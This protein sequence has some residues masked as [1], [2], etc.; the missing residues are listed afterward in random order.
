MISDSITGDGSKDSLAKTVN[1]PN[2]FNNNNCVI[3]AAMAQNTNTQIGA[4]GTG[5]VFSSSS[6]TTGALPL[7]AT[8][9]NNGVGVEI[10]NIVF[11]NGQTP[12]ISNISVKFNYKIV[13]MRID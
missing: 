3:I 8:L 12:I 7:K 10:K 1:F 13:L 4:W 2:G 9:S 6:Y 11:T 5:T